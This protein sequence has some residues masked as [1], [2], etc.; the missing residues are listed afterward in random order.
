MQDVLYCLVREYLI[1]LFQEKNILLLPGELSATENLRARSNKFD[2]LITCNKFEDLLR[3]GI[4][5]SSNAANSKGPEHCGREDIRAR[6]PKDLYSGV[7]TA[8]F[9]NLPT[10]FRRQ[11]L[12]TNIPS[13]SGF[14][15]P[16]LPFR[17]LLLYFDLYLRALDLNPHVDIDVCSAPDLI[18]KVTP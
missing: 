1:F 13:E 14:T 8:K 3:V 16:P 15:R 2:V 5:V 4:K 9:K 10:S 12:P 17:G 18:W 7:G 6:L 11:T